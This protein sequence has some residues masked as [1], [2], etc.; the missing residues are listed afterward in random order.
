MMKAGLDSNRD[1]G[2]VTNNEK[3][4]TYM[5]DDENT[6]MHLPED[7]TGNK[8]F[9]MRSRIMNLSNNMLLE[10]KEKYHRYYA[11]RYKAELELETRPLC[12]DKCVQDITTGLDSREKNCM[13]DCYL[14]RVSTK[15]DFNMYFQQKAAFENGREMRDRLV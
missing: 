2:R 9:G 6:M 5:R 4:R 14:K 1:A 7:Y 11:A 10:P 13:R 8:F 12:F 15:D 3:I